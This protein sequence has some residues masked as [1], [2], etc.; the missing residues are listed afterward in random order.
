MQGSG[1]NGGT[2]MEIKQLKAFLAVANARSFLGAAETLYISRQAVSKIITQLEDELS[3]ELFVRN[4]NG[5]MMTPAGIYFYPRAVTLVADFDK[6]RRDMM[7]IDSAYRP[8]IGICLALGI[9]NVYARRLTEYARQRRAEMEIT[10]SGCLDADCSTALSDRRADAVLSFTPLNGKTA[11]SSVMLESPVRLMVRPGSPLARAERLPEDPGPL[12]LYTGGHETCPWGPRPPRACDVTS[13]DFDFLFALLRDGAGAM[14]LPES[15][16]PAYL[17]FAE[18]LPAGPEIPPGRIYYSTLFS[19]YYD[20][21]TYNLLAAVHK[22][23][24]AGQ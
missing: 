15:V 6:L 22:D 24:L 8:K 13:S 5:A 12:L 17:D 7:D 1:T 4:Q 20:A 11:D 2:I 23:V 18:A 21:L 10:L 14:P 9:Y 3:I 19:S 16:I